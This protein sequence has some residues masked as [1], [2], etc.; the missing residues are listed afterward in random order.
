M[1][2]NPSTGTLTY[3]RRNP[4]LNTGVSYGYQWS[5]SLGAMGWQ[6]FT[7]ASITANGSSPV[8]SVTIELPAGLLTKPGLFIRVAATS[9]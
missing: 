8:E 2:L 4:A 6:A 9:N 5:D 1:P 7:P 3:T